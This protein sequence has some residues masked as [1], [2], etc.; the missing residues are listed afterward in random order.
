M[1]TQHGEVGPEPSTLVFQ[2][3]RLRTKVPQSPGASRSTPE[4][5]TGQRGPGSWGLRAHPPGGALGAPGRSPS[6]MGALGEA[7]WLGGVGSGPTPCPVPTFRFH[8]PL[9]AR[10]PI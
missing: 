2:P 4:T 10:G 6:R 5:Q 8:C 9:M 3:E 1:V 7:P